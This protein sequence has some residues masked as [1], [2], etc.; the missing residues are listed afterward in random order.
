MLVSRVGEVLHAAQTPHP[1]ALGIGTLSWGQLPVFSALDGEQSILP[2]TWDF[3]KHSHALSMHPSHGDPV[4]SGREM[5]PVPRHQWESWS[6]TVSCCICPQPTLQMLFP[7]G[8]SGISSL[9]KVVSEGVTILRINV[10]ERGH[11]PDKNNG[12]IEMQTLILGEL[13]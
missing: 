13:I 2:F 9:P 1:P 7:K 4:D 6:T 8:T 11:C 10:T 12:I 3:P 5:G